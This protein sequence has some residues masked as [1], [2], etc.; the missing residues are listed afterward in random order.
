MAQAER[1]QKGMCAWGF[2]VNLLS[3]VSADLASTIERRSEEEL[4]AAG[5]FAE[6]AKISAK[7]SKIDVKNLMETS[8]KG[9]AADVDGAAGEEEE[10]EGDDEKE[11]EE[12]EDGGEVN[13]ASTTEREEGDPLVHYG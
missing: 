5:F 10:K 11:E 2:F 6:M 8:F 4:D 12:E 9:A 7:L 1:Y 3:N 13:E